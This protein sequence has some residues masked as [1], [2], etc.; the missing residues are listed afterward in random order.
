MR[1][2]SFVKHD[3]CS[4]EI[5]VV[6]F[7][8]AQSHFATLDSLQ[9]VRARTKQSIFRVNNRS[10]PQRP[11]IRVVHNVPH[12]ISVLHTFGRPFRQLFIVR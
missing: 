6:S 11:Q 12:E 3:D 7:V 10:V 2:I 9:S 5:S 4:R 8:R 1:T